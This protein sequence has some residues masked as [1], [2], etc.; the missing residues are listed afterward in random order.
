MENN[1]YDNYVL[2]F[3]FLTFETWLK[4]LKI[5]ENSF[6]EKNFSP[7][8]F[9]C[10]EKF[11]NDEKLKLIKSLTFFE[12]EENFNKYIKTNII[13]L[14]DDI[15]SYLV[16][17]DF[18]LCTN[19]ISKKIIINPIIFTISIA[20][21]LYLR[22][23]YLL[24]NNSKLDFNNQC[25]YMYNQSFISKN[26]ALS[27]I[28]YFF[29]YDQKII[30]LSRI[31]ECPL[32]NLEIFN[33]GGAITWKCI[34]DSIK[35]KIKI[36]DS[37]INTIIIFCK[38]ILNSQKGNLNNWNVC[39]FNPLFHYIIYDIFLE[40][41]LKDLIKELD[42]NNDFYLVCKNNEISIVLK[43][44][45]I[46]QEFIINEI[47]NFLFEKHQLEI[48]IN[49]NSLKSYCSYNILKEECKNSTF[50]LGNYFN[51]LLS[52]YENIHVNYYEYNCLI[53]YHVEINQR[54]LLLNFYYNEKINLN[55]YAR[56]IE[57]IE[58]MSYV[59]YKNII[60]INPK[61]FINLFSKLDKK[62]R[63]K[64]F[65]LK[66]LFL[67]KKCFSIFSDNLDNNF[68]FMFFYSLN[69][70][71]KQFDKIKSIWISSIVTKLDNFMTTVYDYNKLF[72]FLKK[73]EIV[74]LKKNQSLKNSII[75]SYLFLLKTSNFD[76][77]VTLVIAI[78]SSFYDLIRKIA[79]NCL[80]D[81]K[82][83]HNSQKKEEINLL[84]K[85]FLSKSFSGKYDQTYAIPIDFF[86]DLKQIRNKL[87]LIHL[88]SDTY[89]ETISKKNF[90]EI[91]TK[92]KVCSNWLINFFY[93]IFFI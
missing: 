8:L 20:V 26:N 36:K 56:C 67:L 60:S 42:K 3:S 5:I 9:F 64:E 88:D 28:E 19:K 25:I 63:N 44:K 54:L 41:C 10:F 52:Y 82:I 78:I 2:D 79:Y 50:S 39:E 1:F 77:N 31:N 23:E 73:Y 43:N 85:R 66:N 30:E 58:K 6:L 55:E 34:F 80:I 4:A 87:P 61:L 16:T 68:N 45:H 62:F 12:K 11:S 27:N 29:S 53:N 32:I 86:D 57:T 51:T 69:R 71:F 92:A 48:H 38:K 90:N 24:N 70:S 81:I 17:D 13:F 22:D 83:C 75:F 76:E 65:E 72:N 91:K 37:I 93:I 40:K 7:Q 47:R 74:F 15:F 46:N 59:V 89:V 49:S 18:D 33:I 35:S 21:F 84:I 14:Y